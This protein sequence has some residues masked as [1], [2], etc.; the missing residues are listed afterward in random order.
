M[1]SVYKGQSNTDWPLSFHK[2]TEYGIALNIL[3]VTSEGS[4]MNVAIVVFSPS[5]NTFKVATMLE[6]ALVTR[7]LDVQVLDTTRKSKFLGVENARKALKEEVGPHDLLCIG[8]PVY[9]HHLQLHAQNL[10]RALPRPGNGWGKLAVPFVTYGA[11]SSGVALKE[12]ARHL[13]KSGR[14]TVAGMK[15]NSY[16]CLSKRFAKRI[17]EGMP[18][19]EVLPLISDLADRIALLQ[20]GDNVSIPDVSKDLATYQ[21][22]VEQIRSKVIL[23]EWGHRFSFP[24]VKFEHSKCKSCGTCIKNCPVQRIEMTKSGPRIRRDGPGCIQC[25]QCTHNCP[26]EAIRFSLKRFEWLIT[27][28]SEGHGPLPSKEEP[29]SGVYPLL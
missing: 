5:G 16:H 13:K 22:L 7:G 20:K 12:A 21:N 28:G 14:I 2:S 15:I 4:G 9:S 29:K 25:A 27:K 8:G 24:K 3:R 23:H 1:N 18:G 26:Q 11:V 19:D 17:N 10:L 6:K